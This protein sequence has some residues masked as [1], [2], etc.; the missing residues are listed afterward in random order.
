[1]S[2]TNNNSKTL[3]QKLLD[4]VEKV[5]NKVPHPVIIFLILIALVLVLSAHPVHL[6]GQAVTIRGD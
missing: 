1:M 5:G 2:Q 4:V 3:M 6:E